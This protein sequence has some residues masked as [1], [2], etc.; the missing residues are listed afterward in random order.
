MISMVAALAA[1]GVG[2]ARAGE[3]CIDA[4]GVAC[5]PQ[6]LTPEQARQIALDGARPAT[7]PYAGERFIVDGVCWAGEGGIGPSGQSAPAH[8]TYSFPKENTLWGLAV[9]QGVGPND[10][11]SKLI[12]AFGSGNLDLGREYMRAGLAAWRRWAGVSYTEVNDDNSP[13]DQG[14]ARVPTRGDIRI[15]GYASGIQFALAYNAFPAIDAGAVVGGGDMVVNTSFFLAA[16]FTDPA[17][18]YRFFRNT[19]S[20]E[21]GHGLGLYHTIPCNHTKLMEPYLTADFDMVQVDEMRGAQRNYGDRFAGNTGPG[22]ARDFGD[23]APSSG[24]GPRSVREPFLSVNGVNGPGGSGEDWFR[25]SLGTASPVTIGAAP[26]GGVYDE[27]PQL[28]QCDGLSV[29]TINASVA[30]NLLLELRSADGS[31]VLF[32]SNN[33][34]GIA[35]S[36]TANLGAGA[37]SVRVVDA[38]PDAIGAQT[39]QL[40]DFSIRV[41]GQPFGPGA[42]AGVNKRSWA[43][44]KCYFLGDANAW[45]NEP[46]ATVNGYAWDLDG[47]GSFEASGATAF[48]TY[49]SNGDIPVTLRVTDSN[50]LTATDTVTVTVFNAVTTVT[51][52]SPSTAAQGATMPVTI[53]G[54]NFKGVVSAGQF[55][56][57]SV[58]GAVFTGTPSV[59]PLGTQ[60]SGLALFVPAGA[61]AGLT[62]VRVTNADGLGLASS[63]ATSAGVLNIVPPSAPPAAFALQSPA[64]GATAQP[65]TPV[66][67]WAPSNGAFSYGITVAN[68][69]ALTDVVAQQSGLTGTTFAVAPGLL[70]AGRTYYWGVTAT[71]PVGSVASAPAAW[72]FATAPPSLC[73]GDI[74]HDGIRNTGDLVLMLVRFG[75]E[76]LPGEP[77]DLNGDG[78]VNT[79]DLTVLLAVFGQGC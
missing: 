53:I 37:Y 26:V 46:G 44:S 8:L 71:N 11:N 70:Q 74:N 54:T 59:N 2:V 60:V 28:T 56:L 58:P 32:S 79:G 75:N 16:Y 77:A 78:M 76:V 34:P 5:Y 25:F 10:L 51:A 38:G 52:V 33:G 20:H 55:S 35:E 72:S 36:I 49:P 22:T 23:L 69:G 19:I 64:N 62:Q 17:H 27:G 47:D 57:P 43:G 21:H 18:N 7:M 9:V 40:Y 68:D 67:A 14:T 65:L 42:V 50:G 13:M 66:L 1:W 61:A 73:T 48:R 63:D 41:A 3:L 24:G 29:T 12:A 45:A 4:H 39:L 6:N 30:G 15:G 31:T